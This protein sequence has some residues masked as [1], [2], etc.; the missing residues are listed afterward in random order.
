MIVINKQRGWY[1]QSWST[2]AGFGQMKASDGNGQRGMRGA[3]SD[4]GGV[5]VATG[6]MLILCDTALRVVAREQH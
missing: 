3:R 1:T 5:V 2:Q 6:W 4:D